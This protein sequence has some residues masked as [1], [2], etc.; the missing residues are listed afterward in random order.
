MTDFIRRVRDDGLIEYINPRY[1][2]IV[3][4]AEAEAAA[5]AAVATAEPKEPIGEAAAEHKMMDDAKDLENCEYDS[6]LHR[7]LAKLLI[8]MNS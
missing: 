1:D 8:N 4:E 3:A 7:V 2:E 6:R 5:V